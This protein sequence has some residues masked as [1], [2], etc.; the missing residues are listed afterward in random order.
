MRRNNTYKMKR[1]AGFTL[2]EMIVVLVML[3]ILAAVAVPTYTS[4]VDSN[5]AKQCEVE[6]KAIASRLE[7]MQT[8]QV[9]GSDSAADTTKYAEYVASQECPAGGAY[10]FKNNTIVC[11]HTS[12]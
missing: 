8:M 12:S 7:E 10:T 6:R 5:K 4:Y 2:V 3:A 11:S 9:T 1:E